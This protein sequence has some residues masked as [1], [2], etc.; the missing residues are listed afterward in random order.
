MKAKSRCAVRES[1]THLGSF[2]PNKE[3][4]QRSLSSKVKLF[5]NKSWMM[6]VFI[7]LR[8]CFVTGKFPDS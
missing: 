5:H 2:L 3:T 6:I 7:V 1:E 8:I 4:L